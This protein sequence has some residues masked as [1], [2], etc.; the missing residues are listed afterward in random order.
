MLPDVESAFRDEGTLELFIVILPERESVLTVSNAPDK[1]I[2][3]E[4][5]SA[6]TL[7]RGSELLRVSLPD[8]LFSLALP[9]S[10]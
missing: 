4:V 10:P 1:S 6:L 5:L 2:V 8:M 7:E 3:P 9:Y